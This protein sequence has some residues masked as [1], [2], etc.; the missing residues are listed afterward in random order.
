MREWIKSQ[1]HAL[2]LRDLEQEQAREPGACS[3][4]PNSFL[5]PSSDNGRPPA[6]SRLPRAPPS[7]A[8]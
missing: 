8:L 1:M 4:C 2:L 7:L 5:A 6:F 3:Q